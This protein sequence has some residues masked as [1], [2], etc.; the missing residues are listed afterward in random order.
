VAVGSDATSLQS[1]AVN[2]A[3]LVVAVGNQS[4]SGTINWGNSITTPGG[5]N[6]LGS[7]L[8]VA[9]NDQTGEAV[10][11]NIFSGSNES[12]I[13]DVAFS[14]IRQHIAITGYS[15]GPTS[16]QG[17]SFGILGKNLFV[18]Y[19]NT[20]GQWIWGKN[21][22]STSTAENEGRFVQL[23]GNN[24]IYITGSYYKVLSYQLKFGGVTASNGNPGNYHFFLAKLNNTGDVLNLSTWKSET[25]LA[26]S[27]GY[28]V[29]TDTW[30][31]VFVAGSDKNG[32]YEFESKSLTTHNT[33]SNF[34]ILKLNPLFQP[35]WIRSHYKTAGPDSKSFSGISLNKDY[36]IGVGYIKNNSSYDLGNS[37]SI[38]GNHTGFNVALIAYER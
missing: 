27:E 9:F 35:E 34:F 38:L 18:L 19:L 4:G 3:G 26:G 12:Q 30:G 23:F 11:A 36:V 24:E 17:H 8:I 22:D 32:T 20:N 13:L 29:A 31:N 1:V 33:S 15:N 14:K 5:G 10:W 21:P 16:Y 2:N 7:G 25:G 37:V 28:E 6:S